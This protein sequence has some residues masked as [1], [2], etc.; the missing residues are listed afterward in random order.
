M[1]MSAELLVVA[2]ALLAAVLPLAL[3]LWRR[4]SGAGRFAGLGA[5]TLALA[6]FGALAAAYQQTARRAAEPPVSRPIEVRSDGFV[7]SQACR[8][9]HPDQHATWRASYHSRMTQKATPESV[10]APFDGRV[11][12]I[13]HR[14]K[15]ERRGD[16]LFAVSDDPG[17][18]TADVPEPKNERRIVLVSGSHHHQIYWFEFGRGRQ[19]GRLPFF[20]RIEEQRF[21]P[22]HSVFLAQEIPVEFGAEAIWNSSCL[23][24][25]TTDPRPGFGD[26]T[27]MDTKVA[28][29][30][31]AC[32]SCHGPGQA[33]V[34]ANRD[35]LRRYWLH[36]RGEP[37]DTIVN[38]RRLSAE[39]ANDVC[40]FCHSMHVFKDVE[41]ALDFS[42]RGPSFRPGDDIE[43]FWDVVHFGEE[44]SPILQRNLARDPHWMDDRFW[45]DGMVNVVGREY[46]AVKASPCYR[47]GKFSCLS[48]HELHQRADDPRE[49]SEW[50]DD[51]L[52]P[53][54]RGDEACLQCHAALGEDIAAHTHHAPESA[55]SRCQDCHM[56][57]TAWGLLKASRSHQVDSPSVAT[58]LS[59]G[60]M[61]ACNLCHM[62]QTLAWTA[63][64]LADWYGIESPPIAD[65]AQR[66]VSDG[67]LRALRGDAAQ[68]AIAA[69]NMRRPEVRLASG[70]VWMLP[71]LSQLL[72][73]PYDAVR[74]AASGTIRAL[75]GY[76]GVEFDYLGPEP[77]R[78]AVKDAVLAQWQAQG[79]TEP[80]RAELLQQADGALDA[81]RFAE[82]LATRD[83][84]RVFRGE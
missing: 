78:R 83:D 22:F 63:D 54:M 5:A 41:T 33:H 80:G 19:L 25:H 34:E 10:R 61:N 72:L 40:A 50:A 20:Y 81:A 55:G 77:S 59:T 27:K 36:L 42:E 58:E 76:A 46:N 30:G 47:G 62:D 82:L 3:W 2:A 69:W 9:C 67:L 43:K 7:S 6:S 68:R 21:A 4:S 53:A 70:E 28:E 38:P 16:A 48:C 44:P 11:V 57:M 45:P 64:K 65:P 23:R 74:H 31:I 49:P 12:E 29:F 60:R 26:F 32:E 1:W 75:P 37:D 13:G 79:R 56:P 14:Y 66:E 24:C 84:R 51:Q 15:L 17:W 8:A 73:D 39:R 52:D 71:V 35:P 18:L